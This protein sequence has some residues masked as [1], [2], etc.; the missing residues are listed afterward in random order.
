MFG[1]L[2]NYLNL[3]TFGESHAEAYGGI[4]TN[5]PAGVVLDLDKVQNQL[6]KRKPLKTVLQLALVDIIAIPYRKSR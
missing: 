1:G 4:L 3:S 2:G 6:N 5:F